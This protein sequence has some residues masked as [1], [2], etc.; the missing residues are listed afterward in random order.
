M[1]PVEQA[2][3]FFRQG[4]SCSQS[5]LLA[6]AQHYGIPLDVAA[7]ISSGFGGGMGRMGRTCGAVSG[8][9]MVLGLFQ[10]TSNPTDKATKEKTYQ[11]VRSFQEEFRNR[12]GALDCADLL[13]VDISTPEGLAQARAEGRFPGCSRFVEESARLLTEILSENR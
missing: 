6:F 2:S 8:G 3:F 4:Y 13:G 11:L 10:G 12:C 7:R 1:N 5:V 9:A